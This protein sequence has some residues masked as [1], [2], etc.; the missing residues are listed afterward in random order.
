MTPV[1]EYDDILDKGVGTEDTQANEYVGILDNEENRKKQAVKQSFF[2]AAPTDPERQAEYIKLSKQ[3]NLPS[4]FVERNYE[5]VN[6]SN[7][8][9]NQDYDNMIANN[10]ALARYLENVDNSKL[11]KDDLAQLSSIEHGVGKITPNKEK[12]AWLS[13][14]INQ[15]TGEM[16]FAGATGLTNLEAS[17]WHLGAAYG[18]SDPMDAARAAA[19]ANRKAQAMAEVKPDYAKEFSATMQKEGGDVNKGWETFKRSFKEFQDGEIL[20]ALI[21]FKAGQIE[22]VSQVMDMVGKAAIRPR[23]LA[24]SSAENAANMLPSLALGAAGGLAGAKT[25]A[26]VGG[27][28]G[29]VPGAAIGAGIGGTI[30]SVSGSFLGAVPVEIGAWINESLQ[31]RGYDITNENDLYR[32]YTDHKLMAEVRGEAERKGLTTAAVDS[33]SNVYAGKFLRQAKGEGI[34]AGVKAIGKEALVQAASESGGEFAGQAAAIGPEKADFASAIEE[35]ITSLGHSYGEAVVGASRRAMYNPKPVEAAKEIR[36]DVHN[37]I[38]SQHDVQAIFEI[39]EAVKESKTA[40]RVP[41]KIKEFIETIGEENVPSH[42]YFQVD[43]WNNF[44]NKKGRSPVK[45]ADSIMGDSGKRYSES[46]ATGTQLE[47]PLGDYM[48][49]VAGKEEFNELL[50]IAKTRPD[51]M[52]MVEAQEAMKSLPSTME[53]VANEAATPKEVVTVEE[54]AKRVKEKIAE[55]LKATEKFQ[56]SEVEHQ[57]ALHESIF[58]SLATRTKSLGYT[59]ESLYEKYGMRITAPEVQAEVLS[60]VVGKPEVKTYEQAAMK[61]APAFYHKIQKVVEEKMGGSATVEQI[62]GMLKEIK[63][64]ER[65]WSGIDEFLAGK[66][67][68]SKD[69]LQ[70]FLVE[71][72]IEVKDVTHGMKTS[73]LYPTE[74]G[75][76]TLSLDE[77]SIREYGKP[78]AETTPRQQEVMQEMFGSETKYSQYTLPGGENYREVL[79]TLPQTSVSNETPSDQAWRLFGKDS[80]YDLTDEQQSKIVTLQEQQVQK[81]PFKSSHFDEPNILAHVRLD[82]RTDAEGNKVLFVEEIQSDWHQMGREKGYKTPQDTPSVP[83]DKSAARAGLPTVGTNINAVPDAPF[84]KTWHEFAL[85][86]IIRM[87]VEGGYDKIAWTTGEQ[88]ADRYDLSKKISRVQLLDVEGKNQKYLYAYDITGYRVVEKRLESESEAESYIGKD[89]YLKLLEAPKQRDSDLGVPMRSIS[90]KDLKVGGWGMK[91]FYDKMIPDFLKKFGKKFDAKVIETS[92]EGV[93]SDNRD[94]QESPFDT[95]KV[96]SMPIT[97]SL[98]DSVLGEGMS[99]FQPGEEGPLGRIVIS[100]DGTNKT[101]DIELLKGSNPSTF[102]HETGHFY[103][104]VL[105]DIASQENAPENIKKDFETILKHLGVESKD[106][107]KTEHHEKFADTFLSYLMEGKAP[108]QGLR[109]A[110]AR[111]KVWLIS[112][113]RDLKNLNVELTDEVRGVFDRLVASEDEI[114]NASES[115][116]MV[117]L[118]G[119]PRFLGM[120]EASVKKWLKAQD[121]ALE[122]SKDILR[123][124]LMKDLKRAQSEQYNKEYDRIEKEVEA[125]ANEMKIYKAIAHIQKQQYADGRPLPKDFEQIKISKESI[126]LAYGKEFLKKMPRGTTLK[127]KDGGIDMNVAAELLGYVDGDELVTQIVN[128][129][130]KDVFVETQTKQRMQESF[131]DLLQSPELDDVALENLHNEK[132]SDMLRLELEYLASEQFPAL[133]EVVRRVARRVPTRAEVR[134]QAK[135]IIGRRSV[136]N[137]KPHDYLLAERKSSKL[138][139]ELLMKGDVDGAFNAKQKEL[140]NNEMY[141]AALEAKETYKKSMEK[142]KKLY[143][144]DEDLAKTRDMDFVNSARAVLAHHGVGVTEKTP[145]MYL[146]PVKRY[147]YDTYETMIRLVQMATANKAPIRELLYDEFLD[148]KNTVDALWEI[149]KSSRQMTIDETK[150]QKEVVKNTL[151]E[152]IFELTKNPI[153]Y[154]KK[155]EIGFWEGSHLAVLSIGSGLR[156]AES[157]ADAMGPEFI[158]YVWNPVS[159]GVN[160]YREMKANYIKKYLS[161]LEKHKSNLTYEKIRSDELGYT[162]TDKAQLLGALLHTGN[163]SNFAKLLLGR[164][165]ATLNEDGTI[166]STRWNN[167]INRMIR[168]GVLNKADFDF[169]QSVWDLFEEIKPEA[170]KVHKQLYGHYFNEI[171]A[172]ALTNKLGTFKG[173]YV[174]AVVDSNV[175]SSDSTVKEER[176]L[177]EKLDNS[178]MFPTAGRGFTKSRVEGYNRPL[179]MDLRL[180]PMHINKVSKFVKIEPAVKEVGRIIMDG[181]FREAMAALDPEIVNGMLIP[182]LQRTAQ[183]VSAVPSKNRYVDNIARAL[184]TRTGLATMAGNVVNTLQQFLGFSVAAL[185]VKPRYL[186]NSMLNFTKSPKETSKIIQEKSVFMKYRTDNQ[187]MEVQKGIDE[188]ILNPSKYEKLKDFSDKN[189]YIL[190]QHVQNMVDNVVWLGAYDQ[191]IANGRSEKDS[192]RDADSAVRLTQAS[193]NSEDISR[194]ESGSHF[195][196]LFSMFYTYFNT[197]ANLLGSE[198]YKT[199]RDMGVKKGAGRLFYIYVFGFM[200][201]AVLGDLLFIAASGSGFDEDDDEEYLDDFIKIFFGSQIRYATAMFPGGPVIQSG[202]NRFNAKP[203]DDKISLSPAVSAL[204]SAA[205]LPFSLYNS[206]TNEDARSSRAVTD[207]LTAISLATGI[208]V[209]VLGK[210][211]GYALDIKED[212]VE[213]PTGPIDLT[214]GLITGKGKKQ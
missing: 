27:V 52:T 28:T 51:G 197:Q 196:R 33:L 83:G 186:R 53:E 41:E 138:A 72:Q 212:R 85:K 6:K 42:V 66:T 81:I 173:G 60:G 135:K 88:Q 124:S 67:K 112:V 151:I 23:G 207:S 209:R 56:P 17:S 54:S 82:D 1:N 78:F 148:L 118:F 19:E 187:V 180:V 155:K 48:A 178:F 192:I 62:N 199:V 123:T 139:A 204:E 38:K 113:Y 162:F 125:A 36:A 119:D 189:G 140:L 200:T 115:S 77:Y 161:L 188:I 116:G 3:T 94:F 58:K 14:H 109:D 46:V 18:L 194:F 208:P 164:K 146:D 211:I 176:E 159:D 35:G 213:P 74:S 24:Y 193:F 70:T 50:A 120:S 121:E 80:F 89:A 195:Q 49:S 25:G 34:K 105:G 100:A 147:D 11:S 63:P 57:A 99:L 10:P 92:I 107:I 29:S 39:G 185:K 110:F 4:D 2:A 91:V 65:K 190:Q 59:P 68:V 183:Q 202:I 20:K 206:A 108:S 143:R 32:A 203:Y 55:Q 198:F 12:D 16:M 111:F 106:Q 128:T 174:P 117:P 130:P 101:M 137:I 136:E 86:K 37:A 103:L 96:H 170:Q 8:I 43:D 131:P 129:P 166:D 102:L 84:R 165:W 175:I 40:Q 184:R 13:K 122:Y 210:P 97:Q 134:E 153:E 114:T 95:I 61:Q 30:G 163:E 75:D 172:N 177:V 150:V 76:V 133:K 158:K 144:K 149:S 157:W 21:D 71:N 214:R 104:E 142:F 160:Q 45:A 9:E 73:I 205:G 145:E 69:E 181:E 126:A 93:I 154:G 132:R 22:T 5:E 47:I 167:F 152:R 171:T 169:T 90:G 191:A 44:W 87:A 201:P 31:K 64:E 156:K 98:R 182:W 127:A 79:F 26:V 141:R 179:L 15:F 7:L 168:T